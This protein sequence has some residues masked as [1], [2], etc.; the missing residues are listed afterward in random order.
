[1]TS[2]HVTVK[3]MSSEIQLILNTFEESQHQGKSA[4]LATVVGIQGSTYRR[5]GARLLMTDDGQTVGLVSG[6][7]LE[8]D[9]FEH[10]QAMSDYQAKIVTYDH[11]AT[12]DI[13]WG[14]GL[15]CT[16]TVQVLLESLNPP[17][18][19]LTFIARCWRDR[20]AGV[21]V[22]I[23][24]NEDSAIQL[25]ACL[26][27]TSH[28]INVLGETEPAFIEAILPDAQAVLQGRKSVM[29][30]YEL[31]TRHATVWL[32]YIQPPIPLMIFGAG[33]DA[34]PVAEFAKALGWYVT[35]VDCRANP[36]SHERFST[37]DQ[38]ILT[39][40]EKLDDLTIQPETVTVILT[41]NYYDDLEVLRALLPAPVRYIGLLGSKQRTKRLLQ[42]LQQDTHYTEAQLAKLYAPV[43]LDIGAETPAAIA[44]S[45]VAEIQA[46]LSDRSGNSL[47]YRNTSIHETY[48]DRATSPR[49][50]S[51]ETNGN[52]QAVT[53][54]SRA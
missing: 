24:Q 26:M 18:D 45:I 53:P 28:S 21:L 6:G 43:G 22:S 5:P 13:L 25:G 35:V 46:V 7:C 16:G 49:G 1:M 47:K 33:Q 14:F 39:R 54:H 37:S 50:R 4:F 38:V 10:A 15:G 2:K 23:I 31:A 48:P 8:R 44:L 27:L 32:E 3:P 11:T 42:E 19:P 41:H 40:R 17:N 29:K 12:E 9:L 34:I 51:F 30:Q 52:A 20:R 36:L